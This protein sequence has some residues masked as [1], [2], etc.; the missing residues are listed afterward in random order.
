MQIDSNNKFDMQNWNR[1][2]NLTQILKRGNKIH[3]KKENRGKFTKSAKAAGRSVQEHARAVLNDPN[4]TPLQKKRANF[5]RNAAKWHRKHSEGGNIKK[6]IDGNSLIYNSQSNNQSLVYN[7]MITYNSVYDDFNKLYNNYKLSFPVQSVQT[8]EVAPTTDSSAAIEE[9]RRA[10]EAVLQK[11]NST[12]T[13]TPVSS[14]SRT[15][16]SYGK[17]DQS[18]FA[19]EIHQ[20]YVTEL[21]K[22]GL[23]P[24]YADWLT[25]QDAI[26]T[27]WGRSIVGNN[28]YGNIQWNERVHGNKYTYNNGNDKHAN[29]SSYSAKFLNFNSIDDYIAY[30]VGMLSNQNSNRYRDIFNGDVNGFADRIQRS[31]YAESTTYGNAIR[32][33]VDSVR[34]RLNS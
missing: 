19:K 32:Q 3:I 23:N 21:T 22:R 13:E 8:V 11:E 9:L 4:A 7:P 26:E 2:N 27:G 6:Y 17:N 28:N 5:A 20:K 30:K 16:S 33:V 24:A 18:K 1:I 10:G 12:T 29:G 34:K 31:G 14:K 25:A 15:I